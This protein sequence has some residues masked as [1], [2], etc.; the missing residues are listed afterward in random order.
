M[1]VIFVLSC[2]F[3]LSGLVQKQCLLINPR[4]KNQAEIGQRNVASM[5]QS[6]SEA[7]FNARNNA[8]FGGNAVVHHHAG[9]KHRVFEDQYSQ[10]NP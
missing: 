5:L 8:L 6:I 10:N 1:F 3:S 4:K 2:H 9:T 7:I